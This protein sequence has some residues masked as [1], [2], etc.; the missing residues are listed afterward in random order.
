MVFVDISKI[1]YLELDCTPMIGQMRLG[2]SGSPPCFSV[3]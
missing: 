3:T 1:G 2:E